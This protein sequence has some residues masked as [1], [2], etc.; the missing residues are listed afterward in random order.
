M[1]TSPN[2]H[3]EPTP[4]SVSSGE[5][6]VVVPVKDTR[7]GKSR[8]A[9]AVGSDRAVLSGAIAHDTLTATVEAV[10]ARHVVLVTNDEP[11]ALAWRARGVTV[12]DDPGSGL[13]DAVSAGMRQAGAGVRVAALLGDLP[14]L[15]AASLRSALARA[16]D[17][18]ESFVPDRDGTGTVLRCGR[19]FTPHFGADSASRHA[20]D[21]AVRLDLPLPRLRTDVDDARSLARARRLGLGPATQAVLE[22]RASGW[23][24]SMQ[25]S[26]H[27][28][29]PDTHTGSV[30][31]DDGV[32]LA[33]EASAF[34]A[35]G[36]RLLRTGQRLT[37]D[38]VDDVVVSMRIVGIGTGQPIH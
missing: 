38:V 34:E 5:W 4:P 1:P 9:R 35:S 28:F 17:V 23:I 26:V 6:V 14:A 24:R 7:H 22:N 10:G 20:A 13:N 29:D 3:P 30:L 8:L 32:E 36:L 25:A 19:A 11:L 15:D 27:R 16:D 12:V 18:A 37:V 31:R 33:F 21:G 2:A